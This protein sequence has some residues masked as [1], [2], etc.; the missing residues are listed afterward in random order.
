MYRIENS[1]DPTNLKITKFF[2]WDTL[3]IDWNDLKLYMSNQSVQL[4]KSVT[5]P[6]KHKIKTR[7]LIT[8]D[9]MDVQFMIKQGSTWYNLINTSQWNRS[10]EKGCPYTWCKRHNP[11][12]FKLKSVKPVEV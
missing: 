11:E 12:D 3:N 2:L 10:A 8:R 9:D 6:L 5:I 7:N 1:L 4:L